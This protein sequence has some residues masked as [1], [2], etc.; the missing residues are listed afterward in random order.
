MKNNE[1]FTILPMQFPQ[2]KD[3]IDSWQQQFAGNKNFKSIEHFILEDNTFYSLGEIIE[4]NFEIIPIGD[5]ERKLAFVAKND[6]GKV[7]AWFLL[8]VFDLN[9]NE[10]E[11]F[12]QYIVIHPEYQNSGLGTQIAKEIF[13]SPEKYVGVKPV[14]IFSYIHQ[15]NLASQKLFKKF[16]FSLYPSGD[17]Y[18]RAWT[19]CPKFVGDK[20]P[21]EPGE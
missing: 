10:P 8:H 15:V 17:N 19:D 5:D 20:K 21:I 13:L 3:E 16:N 4:T 12:F 18:L 7:V 1:K 11:M 6:E 2:D 9:T 14:E